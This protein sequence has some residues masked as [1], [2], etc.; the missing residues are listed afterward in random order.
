MIKQ[1]RNITLRRLVSFALVTLSLVVLFDL[2]IQLPVGSADGPQQKVVTVTVYV[3][4][5]QTVIR[6]VCQTVYVQQPAPYPVT[7]TQTVTRTT[8]FALNY[9]F[10]YNS[11]VSN[12]SVSTYVVSVSA[13]PQLNIRNCSYTSTWINTNR[14]ETIEYGYYSSGGT[15]FSSYITFHPSYTFTSY[16]T[17]VITQAPVT[18]SVPALFGIP[19]QTEHLPYITL[20]VGG[21]GGAGLGY[22]FRSATYRKRT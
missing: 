8:S 14:T 22:A 2:G 16:T 19:I 7:H 17:C 21:L 13:T 20:I 15:T 1:G 9:S 10:T 5:Y 4:R 12:P 3:P 6:T 18:V 11:T